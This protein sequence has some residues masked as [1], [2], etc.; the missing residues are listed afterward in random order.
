MNRRDFIKLSGAAAAS[1]TG[2]AIG[3]AT[4]AGAAVTAVRPLRSRR[5]DLSRC[6]IAADEASTP[7][8]SRISA[9]AR[10]PLAAASCGCA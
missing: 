7:C 2:S 6:A 8:R 4:S 1:V 5:I 3:G 10:C 9:R